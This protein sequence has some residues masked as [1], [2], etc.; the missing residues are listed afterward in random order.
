[1]CHCCSIG[2]LQCI[3]VPL[4]IIMVQADNMIRLK[5]ISRLTQRSRMTN[6]SAGDIQATVN[7]DGRVPIP[8]ASMTM[9]PVSIEAVDAAVN[10]TE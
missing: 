9:L 5:P 3:L 2:Q 8:N 7:M 10:N 4:T 6:A 1:M